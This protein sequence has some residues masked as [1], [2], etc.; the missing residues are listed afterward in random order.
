MR[1]VGHQD[2]LDKKSHLLV[3]KFT[4]EKRRTEVK[5]CVKGK[6]NFVEQSF[7]AKDLMSHLLHSLSSRAWILWDAPLYND[8]IRA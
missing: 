3:I 8:K 2:R 4:A 5:I 1:I 6:Q 7:L